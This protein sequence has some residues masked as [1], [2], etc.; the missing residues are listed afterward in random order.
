[1]STWKDPFNRP[2]EP[3]S[4]IWF[5][6][7]PEVT[8]P[9]Q[10]VWCPNEGTVTLGPGNSWSL[11]CDLVSKW[12]PPGYTIPVPATGTRTGWR[13]PALYPPAANQ[14]CWIRRFFGNTA[15]VAVHWRPEDLA[16][17]LT[18]SEE[19]MIWIEWYYVWQW[20]PR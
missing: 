4:T 3:Y 5:R 7:Y 12:R 18:V 15:A 13:D 6:R 10:G 1:M 14:P 8:P 11:P 17:V 9:L 20:K 16:F 19:Y 2:P